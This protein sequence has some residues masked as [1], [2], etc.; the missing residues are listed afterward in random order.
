MNKI[1]GGCSQ[2]KIDQH[3]V[4]LC[5]KCYRKQPHILNKEKATNRVY[6]ENNRE[7]ILKKK[8][9]YYQNNIESERLKRREYEKKRITN[10]DGFKIRKNVRTRVRNFL[11][12]NNIKAECSITKAIG[13]NG[14]ELEKYI[15]SKFTEDM[16]WD[17]YGEWHIDHIDAL[18]NYDLTNEEELKKAVHYTNLQP[19]WAGENMSWGSKDKGRI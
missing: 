14:E 1:C 8:K 7:T 12:R 2:P 5:R 10:D 19:M 3:H 15:E 4:T 6:R 13:I 18:A 17:N 16:S 11:K 9:E